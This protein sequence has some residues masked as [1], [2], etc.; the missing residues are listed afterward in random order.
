MKLQSFAMLFVT[1]AHL[2]SACGDTRSK[3][4]VRC[5]DCGD[6]DLPDREAVARLLETRNCT[7][8]NLMRANFSK[9]DL[10]STNLRGAKLSMAVLI[11]TRLDAANLEDANLAMAIPDGIA[12]LT[13]ASL[14]KVNLKNTKLNGAK[15]LGA[16]LEGAIFDG[17][18]LSDA[19]LLGA[20]VD[21]HKLDSAVLCRTVLPDGRMASPT[22]PST[23]TLKGSSIAKL[24]AL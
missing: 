24:R 14:Q 8:C 17:T 5:H 13:R 15:L 7:G 10:S 9:M 23:M 12:D 20:K 3:P 1:L 22:C 4:T 6:S 2:L 19:S 16:D 21:I 18:D 11:E